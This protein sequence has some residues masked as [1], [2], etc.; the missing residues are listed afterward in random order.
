MMHSLN[1][2][3]LQRQTGITP[4]TGNAQ[5]LRA[6]DAADELLLAH[7]NELNILQDKPRILLINDNFGALAC[8]LNHYQPDN[9][10]DS[11]LGHC[12]AEYNRLE[13][14]L[15]YSTNPL[16]STESPSG[17]YDLVLIKLPKTL[18][19]LEHQLATLT[20]HLHNRSRVIAAGMVKYM[21]AS[22][23]ELLEKYIGPTNA[24]LAVKKARLLFSDC[25]GTVKTTSPY[26]SKFS[27]SELSVQLCNHASVFSQKKLDIGTRFIL[28]HFDKLP[29]AKRIIDLGC[30]NGLLGIMAQRQ[31]TN[32]KIYFI[33]ESY[34]AI[35]S[36]TENYRLN[37]QQPAN[38][39]EQSLLLSDCLEQAWEKNSETK[40][41]DLILCNPP[42][43]QQNTV[44]DHIALKMFRQSF[45]SLNPG[46]HLW[47]V[48][49]RH[50]NYHV[51]LKRLFGNTKTIASNNKFVLLSAEKK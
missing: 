28:E 51:K 21:Q 8:S 18:A 38:N 7:I 34:M 17:H 20:A 37:I 30:G 39:W 22:H 2:L 14:Q 25:T 33:D 36:A 4:A 29:T 23:S 5:N 45:Q 24:S 43:H 13:N 44:G 3:T 41:V 32:S 35:A 15:P 48:G 49:N 50:L 9:W 6:W 31:L 42:F 11:Y 27:Q 26:P 47:V 19:L 1:S 46:G 40:A 10:G 12:I 16:P